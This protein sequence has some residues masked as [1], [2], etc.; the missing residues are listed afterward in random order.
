MTSVLHVITGL[1][2]GGAETMLAQLAAGLQVRGIP[3]HVVCLKERG[4]VADRLEESG[5]PVTCY[6]LEASKDVPGGVLKLAGMIRKL[7]PRFVQGWMY[8]GNLVAAL[9]HKLLPGRRER[10]LLWNIRASNM[11]EERYARV[12]GWSARLSHWPDLLIANS[13]AGMG[14]HMDCGFR[15]RAC[16]VI[17]NGIDTEKFRPDTQ[18]RNEIRK[19]WG[20]GPEDVVALQVA[21]VDPMKDHDTYLAALG[22]LP[23]VTGVLAGL[24][25]DRLRLSPNVRA[26]GLRRDVPRLCAAADIIVSSSAYGE[27]F[28]NALA[29]GMSAGLVP[30]ATR[31]G[32]SAV[33]ADDIG[34]TVQPRDPAALSAAIGKVAAMPV[35]LRRREGL[36][37]RA[38]IE[39]NFSLDRAIDRFFDIY[40]GPAN[41]H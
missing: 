36:K 4:P 26:L 28:S 1:G 29:E 38:R 14:F 20:V 8:H 19:E 32:D 5:V 40:A 7:A 17:P 22:A 15:P 23:Q 25:T 18:A 34:Q 12:I 3:Q 11:D 6:G 33:I 21:R 31:V 13:Q 41:A 10:K 39:R 16:E 37:A 27:G 2:T 35:A 24:D 9:A 30:V